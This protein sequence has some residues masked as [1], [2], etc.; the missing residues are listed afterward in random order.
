MSPA[1]WRTGGVELRSGQGR[2]VDVANVVNF[3]GITIGTT[4]KQLV[5]DGQQ[6]QK[7]E[8]EAGS[9]TQIDL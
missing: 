4:E 1:G 3:V 5:L 2:G 9:E 7:L 8:G 6:P